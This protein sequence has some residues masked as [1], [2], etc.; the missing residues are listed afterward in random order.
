VESVIEILDSD[1]DSEPGSENED[2]DGP[3]T[4]EE[5]MSNEA[6]SN[7]EISNEAVCEDGVPKDGIS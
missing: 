5:I 1:A 3:D 4:S 6:I 7:E 2:G